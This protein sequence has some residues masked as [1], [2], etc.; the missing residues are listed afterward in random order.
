MRVSA[1]QSK[2]GIF[3]S[4]NQVGTLTNSEV[5]TSLEYGSNLPS[6]I[7]IISRNERDSG[8]NYIFLADKKTAE[9]LEA[10]GYSVRMCGFRHP[11]RVRMFGKSGAA[12]LD[13]PGS[14]K[15]KQTSPAK[16][17]KIDCSRDP[18]SQS[19]QNDSGTC[20]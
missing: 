9:H 14:A 8:F 4:K 15:R 10:T 18:V 20:S 16:V 2:F 6:E 13:E 11:L 3:I 19:F 12:T 7:K 1:E 5:Q 17:N